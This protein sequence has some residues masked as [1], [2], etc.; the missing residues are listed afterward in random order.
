MIESTGILRH[1]GTCINSI[2]K[3]NPSPLQFPYIFQNQVLNHTTRPTIAKNPKYRWIPHVGILISANIL[4][5]YQIVLED[6]TILEMSTHLVEIIIFSAAIIYSYVQ[7]HKSTPF[8]EYLN[9]MIQFE[10]RWLGRT[11]PAESAYWMNAGYRKVI[12]CGL[13]MFQASLQMNTFIQCVTT[14]FF[15]KCP[16]RIAPLC[17]FTYV[18]TDRS[19]V[20]V[21]WRALCVSYAYIAWLIWDNHV[22][23]LATMSFLTAQA[24]LYYT[25]LAVRRIMYK[26]ALSIDGIVSIYREA[27]LLGWLYND[28]HKHLLIPVFLLMTVAGVSVCLFQLVS[29]WDNLNLETMLVFGNGVIVGINIVLITFRLAV[30]LYKESEHSLLSKISTMHAKN[31]TERRAAKMYWK[32]FT[33][34]KIYFFETNFFERATPLVVL[35]FIISCAI[36][37]ILLESKRTHNRA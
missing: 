3:L 10:D 8:A 9:Q 12:I 17:V 1:A 32:S 13:Y 36:N 11:N 25:T 33:I 15:P 37:M 7:Y 21:T 18:K 20:L 31:Q 27:Q 34:L 28:I 16:W 35:N 14:I 6:S 2:G 19:I 26:N 5:L 22:V 4:F 30:K 29:Q 23:V 24:S